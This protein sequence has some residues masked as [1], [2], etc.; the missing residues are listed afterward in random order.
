[1][2]SSIIET[3]SVEQ[4]HHR[5]IA[6][7]RP[8]LPIAHGVGALWAFR[9]RPTDPNPPIANQMAA[10]AER[11]QVITVGLSMPV[12]TLIS[13]NSSMALI[14]SPRASCGSWLRLPLG[15]T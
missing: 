14:R 13:A 9:L 4:I 2:W 12:R 3:T 7:A 5:A 11:F 10:E 8:L 6:I 1:M 15:A